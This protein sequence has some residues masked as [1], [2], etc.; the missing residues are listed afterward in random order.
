VGLPLAVPTSYR[1]TRAY[2]VENVVTAVLFPTVFAAPVLLALLFGGAPKRAISGLE[3]FFVLTLVGVLLAFSAYSIARARR[4]EERLHVT[5]DGFLYR[6]L[7]RTHR[8][9]WS[10]V[11]RARWSLRR[12]GTRLVILTLREPAKPRKLKIDLEGVSPPPLDFMRQVWHFAP[13]TLEMEKRI[14][15]MGPPPGPPPDFEQMRAEAREVATGKD[16]EDLLAAAD[17]LE[18]FWKPYLKTSARKPAG[19]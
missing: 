12:G 14:L 19:R 7:R 9:A 1:T 5:A 8:I 6:G 10:D 4:S 17:D 3:W 2:R 15:K 16:L 13:D 11:S 18:R